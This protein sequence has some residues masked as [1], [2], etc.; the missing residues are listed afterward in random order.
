[1]KSLV[2]ANWKMNPHTLREA[3]Y[4]FE[5]TRKAADRARD[6]S[7]VIA[8]PAI[9]LRDLRRLYRGKRISFGIQHV[10]SEP[11]GA[12]TGE[13]SLIQAADAGATWAI[14][15]HAERRAMGEVDE[16]VR[17]KVIATIARKMT[18]VLC[19]GENTRDPSGEHFDIV[20][21]QLKIGLADV[22]AAK[23]GKVIIAYEPVWAIGG[24]EMMKPHDMHE[25]TIFI[26]KTLFEIYGKPGM[27]A[28]ILYG[29]SIDETNAP[30]MLQEGDVQGL[31]VG[32]ASADARRFT[33]LLI[34]VQKA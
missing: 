1:M 24:A 14:I 19:I 26:R 3:K 8:P 32:R 34:A 7:I 9:F 22:P 27:S 17:K 6:V 13:M 21:E 16:D 29:G 23:L 33:Q 28:N 11:D 18:P 10:R 25:M 30:A 12:F 2:I 31:L 5:G 4:L 20:K 15:G